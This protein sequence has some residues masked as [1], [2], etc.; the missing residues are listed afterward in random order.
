MYATYRK[1]PNEGCSEVIY[2]GTIMIGNDLNQIITL[3]IK[4]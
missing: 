2:I 1:H 4:N 3:E